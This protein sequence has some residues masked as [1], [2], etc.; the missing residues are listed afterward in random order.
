ML[1]APRVG[2][3]HCIDPAEGRRWP[4]HASRLGGL[5]N[6]RFHCASAD[7]IPMTDGSQD[8]GYSLGVLDH[9]PD[10]GRAL[11]DCVRKLKRGAPFLLYVYYALDER[12]AWFRG[13]WEQAT[14]V[15][16]AVAR[17]PFPARKA[18]T[19]VVAA[20]VLTRPAA[21]LARI[22]ERAEAGM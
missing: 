4:S 8:F 13:L 19:G 7:A 9:I 20:I 14:S 16:R 15:R 5:P 12:P 1:V 11:A 2:T 6:V 21:R 18:V 3:L 10:T 22:A 17:L